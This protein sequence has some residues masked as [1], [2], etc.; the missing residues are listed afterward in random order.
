MHNFSVECQG[1]VGGGAFRFFVARGANRT[2]SLSGET[3]RADRLEHQ[4]HRGD[5]ARLKAPGLP[6]IIRLARALD[7]TV[8]ELLRDF[9]ETN[10]RR[11]S[12]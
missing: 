1:V 12:V 9:T 2:A 3:R 8:H 7:M 10:V 4:L 6:V 5:G 11:L